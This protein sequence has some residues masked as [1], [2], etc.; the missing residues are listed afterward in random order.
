MKTKALQ[1]VSM[2]KKVSMVKPSQKDKTK[3]SELQA[4]LQLVSTMKLL[5]NQN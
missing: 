3:C 5:D 2:A 4:P 1:Y